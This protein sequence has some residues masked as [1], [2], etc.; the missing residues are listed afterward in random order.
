MMTS[1]SATANYNYVP[2]I[3]GDTQVT[4]TR[5]DVR[6]RG[7]GP[8]SKFLNTKN[9][10]GRATSPSASSTDP[11]AGVDGLAGHRPE[12]P[13]LLPSSRPPRHHGLTIGIPSTFT[14]RQRV[15]CPLSVQGRRASR[16]IAPPGDFFLRVPSRR[17]RTPSERSGA[18]SILASLFP[19]G[20]AR[21]LEHGSLLVW[22]GVRMDAPGLVGSTPDARGRRSRSN[23][24]R[25]RHGR[26]SPRGLRGA[27]PPGSRAGSPRLLLVAPGLGRADV[28][29][30][31]R[32]RPTAA[33][34]WP[35][36]RGS[37]TSGRPTRGSASC[38]RS[39][40]ART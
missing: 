34:R 23:T 37:S 2:L 24:L 8:A 25:D 32:A 40:R 36:W 13:A 27:D 29:A 4:F 30:A 21:A 9:A 1:A 26:R 38:W 6:R 14:F 19:D 35:C 39:S 16:P 11:R 7:C 22:D 3:G 10:T 15:R 28:H 18:K 5:V 31:R 12:R 20:P 17:Q 33:T